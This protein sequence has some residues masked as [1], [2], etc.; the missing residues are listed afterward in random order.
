[1]A[2][3]GIR[4]S[5]VS[6]AVEVEGDE[7]VAIHLHGQ[8]AH[9]PRSSVERQVAR[10]LM[11]YFSGHRQTFS[12]PVRLQGSPFQR[13]VWSLVSAIPYGATR[14]Y[15]EIAEALGGK[16]V[17]RAVGMAN[18]DN[19]IPIVIPC[20]RV[21]ASGGALGGYGGGRKL[22]SELLALEQRTAGFAGLPLASLI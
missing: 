7:L 18:H 19:P 10:Q 17:S 14:T 8:D 1:M 4:T 6:L 20:H 5:L 9:R 22:K 3:F 15:G 16:D 21:V 12:L 13:A 2:R 11:E